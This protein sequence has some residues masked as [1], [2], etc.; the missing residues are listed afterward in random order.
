MKYQI[1]KFKNKK[2]TTDLPHVASMK[3]GF[4]L[5]ETLVALSIFTTAILSIMTIVP[6]GLSAVRI[7]QDKVTASY[8]AQEGIDLVRAYR[9]DHFIQNPT[10]DILATISDNTQ[11]GVKCYID[12]TEPLT[13]YPC[14]NMTG[15]PVCPFLP[16]NITGDYVYGTSIG[17]INL[18]TREISVI[19]PSVGEY[20]ITSTVNWVLN[21]RNYSVSYETSLT[22]WHS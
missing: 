18:F 20:Q 4:T 21:S 19:S 3:Q 2:F 8:L 6:N 22:N 11:C 1:L 17:Q 15:T 9:D 10:N 14:P 16:H 7:A 5:I 12:T 13:I